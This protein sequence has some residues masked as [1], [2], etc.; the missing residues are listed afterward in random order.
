MRSFIVAFIAVLVMISGFLPPVLFSAPLSPKVS[1][2]SW[3]DVESGDMRASQ[4][5]FFSE[6]TGGSRPVEAMRTPPPDPTRVEVYL[7][8]VFKPIAIVDTPTTTPTATNTP[9]A[10]ATQQPTATPTATQVATPTPTA[11]E[12]VGR[13]YIC[14][15]N[16]YNC[17]DFATQSEAQA[18]YEYCKALNMGDIHKL[19][20]DEDGI[21]CEN[22]PNGLTL[23]R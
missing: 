1:V 4:A 17:T 15:Y 13:S 16:A 12:Q 9:T 14:S 6:T 7:P 18:V 21:A 3:N 23:V 8:A 2:A 19:D 22:L 5:L 10:T 20:A 11:T